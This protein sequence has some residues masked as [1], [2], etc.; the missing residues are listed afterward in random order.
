MYKASVFILFE[1]EK[2]VETPWKLFLKMPNLVYNYEWGFHFLLNL[3]I[4]NIFNKVLQ[5]YF[6]AI[7]VYLCTV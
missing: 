3:V 7:L 2:C 4:H 6:V 5:L 1:N